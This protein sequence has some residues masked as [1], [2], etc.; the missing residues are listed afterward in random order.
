MGIGIDDIMYAALGFLAAGLLAVAIGPAIWN[1]AVRLTKRRIEAVTPVTLSEFRADKDKLRAEFAIATRRMETR[2]EKL[3]DKLVEASVAIDSQVQENAALKAERD[4]QYEAISALKVREQELVAQIRNLERDAASLAAMVRQDAPAGEAGRLLSRNDAEGADISGDQLTGDYRS[5]VE[6]LLTALTLERQRNSWLEDQAQMLLARL[7]KKK[8]GAAGDE[9]VALLRDTLAKGDPSSEARLELH[10]A[11]ARVANAEA[12]LGA[13]LSDTRETAREPENQA[14]ARS[15]ADELSQAEKF[16][17]L[18]QAVIALETDAEHGW[19]SK[20]YDAGALRAQLSNI[21]ADTARLVY[22]EDAR[23]I[24]AEESESLF[25]RV[26]KFAEDGAE[27]EDLPREPEA[28]TAARGPV[29]DRM[30]AL[31]DLQG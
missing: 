27:F 26:R 22:A 13:L 18:K 9:A 21:A 23:E 31:R 6:D 11:E 4:E 30:A 3:R 10:D 8:K 29:A 17:A 25:D 19:G 15:L 28:A 7:E 20:R 24:E 14:V 16:D 2:I 5:D 12:R 1:R